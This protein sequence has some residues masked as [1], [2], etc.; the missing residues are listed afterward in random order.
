M[1]PEHIDI[2]FSNITKHWKTRQV[3]AGIDIALH[4]GDCMLI[5]GENGSGKSTLLRIMAGLLKPDHAWVSTGIE[6]QAWRYYRKLLR[7]QIMY[8]HQTPYLFDSTVEK[9]LNYVRSS[10]DI[11]EAMQW[12]GI[13][14]LA[15]QPA[16]GLSGGERQRVALARVWLKQPSIL[17]LDEP[18]ANLDQESRQRTIDLLCSLKESGV[19]IVIASH[20]PV[21]FNQVVNA[22]MHLQNGKLKAA[23]TSVKTANVVTLLPK[24]VH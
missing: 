21:H 5:T 20:D 19:A 7:Q 9:N 23:D 4:G 14:H 22:H 1:N 12:A 18:T 3:L 16:Y 15:T 17:L 13:S 24:E 2:Y 11:K 6:K 10:L 8:L